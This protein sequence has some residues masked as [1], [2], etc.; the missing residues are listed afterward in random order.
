MFIGNAQNSATYKFL[1]LKD[2][3]NVFDLNTIIKSKNTE[4]FESIFP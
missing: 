3:N 4:F 1:V 2:Q